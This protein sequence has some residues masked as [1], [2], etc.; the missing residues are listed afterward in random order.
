[1]QSQ[2]FVLLGYLLQYLVEG[3]Y[4]RARAIQKVLECTDDN[5]LVQGIK[6]PT[7]EDDFLDLILTDKEELIWDTSKAAVATVTTSW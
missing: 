1:M 3:S 6:E 4:S 5:V 2:A 7:G